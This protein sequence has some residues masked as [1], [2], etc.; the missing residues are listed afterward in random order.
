MSIRPTDLQIIVQ[1]AQEVERLQQARQQ[2]PK[3]HEQQFA[4]KL[5]KQDEI[6]DRQ[7]N[8]TPHG[9]EARVQNRERGARQ[10]PQHQKSNS[11]PGK[12]IKAEN[13][14]KSTEASDHI[15]DI[16]I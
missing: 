14:K 4:E 6:R 2:Q 7:I 5:H 11:K 16:I 10:S 15:I 9:D 12:Q 13:T 8:S 1:K 3:I